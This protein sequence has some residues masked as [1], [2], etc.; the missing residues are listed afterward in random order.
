MNVEAGKAQKHGAFDDGEADCGLGWEE[1]N[2]GYTL[3]ATSSVAYKFG[4]PDDLAEESMQYDIEF[5]K[6]L[7][8]RIDVVHPET[9]T[10][11]IEEQEW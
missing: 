2:G 1:D 8:T 9:Y 10:F 4:L 3:V 6:W 11:E 5:A 7:A